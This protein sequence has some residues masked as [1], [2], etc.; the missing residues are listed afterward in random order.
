MH[1]I[2]VKDIIESEALQQGLESNLIRAIMY[3]ESTHGY[4]D[5]LMEVF[6]KN[7]SILPMNVR[8]DYWRD[9][10]F[11]RTALKKS[12]L[13][14]HFIQAIREIHDP[15]LRRLFSC[16]FSGVLEFNNLFCSFKGEG[17]EEKN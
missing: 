14:W 9:S 15:D 13:I 5:K 11:S 10:G 2:P 1:N 8:S 4:Y 6:D 12:V 7:N 3:M 16:L 17:H